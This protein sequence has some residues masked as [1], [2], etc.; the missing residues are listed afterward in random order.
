MFGNGRHIW[1][2]T[3]LNAW[4]ASL[5]LLA[6]RPNAISA[7]LSRPA[8]VHVGK[9]SYGMYLFHPSIERLATTMVGP[10]YGFERLA[11]FVVYFGAVVAVSSVSYRWY[12]TPFLRL[13]DKYFT[14]SAAIDR[15]P[16]TDQSM[17]LRK[18]VE[19]N[20]VGD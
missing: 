2:Y 7:L 17:G 20:V 15:V 3:L 11:V 18:P 16:A 1:G 19:D 12:E 5:L 10:R 14:A 4:A 6:C 9:I 13:K 8:L